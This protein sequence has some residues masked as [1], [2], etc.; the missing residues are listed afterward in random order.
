MTVLARFSPNFMMVVIGNKDS[1]A[2]F[3]D[4]FQDIE[5]YEQFEELDHQP[6]PLFLTPYITISFLYILPIFL[7]IIG[8]VKG[9]IYIFRWL[10]HR[11]NKLPP[12]VNRDGI[13]KSMFG[14]YVWY[15][16]GYLVVNGITQYMIVYFNGKGTG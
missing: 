9:L 13:M 4:Q 15:A 2:T 10:W 1:C 8:A 7:V 5:Y 12:I 11:I 16:L 6:E 14:K 3:L